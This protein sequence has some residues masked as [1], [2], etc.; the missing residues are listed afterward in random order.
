MNIFETELLVKETEKRVAKDILQELYEEAL[1][2]ENQV[3]D[4][5][6]YYIRNTLAKQYGVEVEE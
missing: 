2:S 3:V 6:A 4:L 1:R 5:T